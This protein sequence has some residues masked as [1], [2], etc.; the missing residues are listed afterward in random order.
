MTCPDPVNQFYDSKTGKCHSCPEGYVLNQSNLLCER[1]TVECAPGQFYD[2]NSRLCKYCKTGQTYN[3]VTKV[4]E[5]M[6]TTCTGGM[7]FDYNAGECKYC[8]SG[9]IYDEG[10]MDCRNNCTVDQIF[11]YN[12]KLCV[13]ISST[14]NSYQY[15]DPVQR[16]CIL[17]AICSSNQRYD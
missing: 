5:Y 17:R 11:D 2:E 10:L 1:K 9:Y 8:P 16:K 15:Y 4:C 14:C 7:Y 12:K 3:N 6:N 13:L